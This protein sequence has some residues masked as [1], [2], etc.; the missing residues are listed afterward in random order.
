M[1]QQDRAQ[2]YIDQ[3]E[4]QR[5]EQ[6]HLEQQRRSQ[7]R[8]KHMVRAVILFVVVGVGGVWWFSGSPD[9]AY[10]VWRVVG[11]ADMSPAEARMAE[12]VMGQIGM[13]MY[14]GVDQTSLTLHVV[15]DKGTLSN[16]G[17]C[18]WTARRGKLY[19]KTSGCADEEYVVTVVDDDT[20]TLTDPDS[21]KGKGMMLTRASLSD[22]Q[23]TKKARKR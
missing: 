13:G 7:Q 2:F 8:T 9:K 5:A 16:T 23:A 6:Q 15:T 1:Y 19:C 22:V 21:R 12:S 18:E 4:Q 3:Q 20:I 14:F 10:G 17:T 11:P